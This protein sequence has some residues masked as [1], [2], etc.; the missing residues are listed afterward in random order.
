MKQ[1]RGVRPNPPSISEEMKAWSAALEDEVG[2]SPQVST[3]GFS[4]F[5]AL[6]RKEKIFALLPRTRGMG[7][8]NALAFKLI[9]SI[10]AD[11]RGLAGD[12][13][14]VSSQMQKARWFTFE[15]SS[16]ADLHDALDG[17]G[18]AYV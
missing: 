6:Y 18:R 13:R 9:D 7:T 10:P 3:R 12:F 5:T 8:A 1:P 17:L 11:P 14:N 4:G 15:L 16:D 2:G